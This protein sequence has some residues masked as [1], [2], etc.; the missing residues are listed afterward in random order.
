MATPTLGYLITSLL[1]SA[2]SE[3]LPN[4]TK[5]QGVL[6][7]VLDLVGV[8]HK[9]TKE[10]PDLSTDAM[11][12]FVSMPGHVLYT[13][14]WP[15][16]DNTGLP[17]SDFDD[18]K[19]PE[20]LT[21]MKIMPKRRNDKLCAFHRHR[22]PRAPYGE[23]LTRPLKEIF[24]ELRVTVASL[25]RDVQKLYQG[26]EPSEIV[27]HAR[28]LCNYS[29]QSSN[30]VDKAIRLPPKAGHSASKL[31]TFNTPPLGPPCELDLWLDAD[32][33]TYMVTVGWRTDRI[34]FRTLQLFVGTYI[35]YKVPSLDP[36]IDSSSTVG[37][38]LIILQYILAYTENFMIGSWVCCTTLFWL[39]RQTKRAPTVNLNASSASGAPSALSVF[40]ALLIWEGVVDPIAKVTVEVAVI[41]MCCGPRS[42][43]RTLWWAIST[44]VL[45]TN[46]IIGFLRTN[47]T[48]Q[49]ETLIAKV[50]N[51]WFLDRIKVLDKLAGWKA[52]NPNRIGPS[53]AKFALTPSVA[54]YSAGRFLTQDE[55]ASQGKLETKR[56]IGSLLSSAKFREWKRTNRNRISGPLDSHCPVQPLP[57]RKEGEDAS[58]EDSGASTMDG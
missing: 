11:H 10:F 33:V 57:R 1:M 19:I 27:Q 34:I 20:S 9:V 28:I 24:G 4:A 14:D 40:A 45:H 36:G 38:A 53:P 49:M 7:D 43:S 15:P 26:E 16:F 47:P 52:L 29:P 55:F 25:P 39:K 32:N 3:F 37:R 50:Q 48:H 54:A 17:A 44:V 41:L 23:L 58:E 30:T 56:Q 5:I 35:L 13:V 46:R 8:E 42:M 2:T 18:S 21:G 31:F 12:T 22:L 51:M 6:F